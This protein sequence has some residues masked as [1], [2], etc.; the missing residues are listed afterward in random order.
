MGRLE[1]AS[2]IDVARGACARVAWYAFGRPCAWSL[3]AND[4]ARVAWGGECDADGLVDALGPSSVDVVDDDAEATLLRALRE[5][6]AGK[7][8]HVR[9]TFEA[10]LTCVRDWLRDALEAPA[11]C[12]TAGLGH[13]AY[14]SE[15]FPV[16]LARFGRD[17]TFF[18]R[19]CG[20]ACERLM[21]LYGTSSQRR[22]YRT[23][24]E[25]SR[26]RDDDFG[27]EAVNFY[28]GETMRARPLEAGLVTLMHAADILSVLT[29]TRERAAS[30]ALG[31]AM[32]LV[33]RAADMLRAAARDARRD[34]ETFAWNVDEYADRLDTSISDEIVRRMVLD[35]P[36]DARAFRD[37]A[38]A[39]AR[40]RLRA[41]R[42]D[43]VLVLRATG[44]FD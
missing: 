4:R 12:A 10:H 34:G 40:A 23:A 11:A 35:A 8:A 25:D 2:A 18:A 33:S 28:T 16:R 29:P 32:Y 22:W 15:L 42:F 39:R 41:T 1:R 26:S 7:T 36:P 44:A 6:N 9:G 43:V 30:T 17:R 27:F 38:A 21:F 20:G 19:A 24:L 31:F 14:G 13:T 3:C 5:A 37:A